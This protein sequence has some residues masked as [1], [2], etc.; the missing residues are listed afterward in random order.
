MKKFLM[1]AM[2]LCAAVVAKADLMLY[3]TVPEDAWNGAQYAAIMGKTDSGY[4]QLGSKVEIGG[5]ADTSIGSSNSYVDYM[6]SLFTYAGGAWNTLANSSSVYTY[7]QLVDTGST[8]E[9]LGEM[10]QFAESP[11]NFSG[12]TA[13]IPEPTSGLMLLLGLGALALKRKRV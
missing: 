9:D 10:S 7:N 3:W 8:Y 2:V 1:I 11:Y 5:V 12:F 13:A 6:V 4:V